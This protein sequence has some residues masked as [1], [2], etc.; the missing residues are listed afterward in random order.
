MAEVEK[1]DP[2]ELTPDVV[3]NDEVKAL[4]LEP[5]LEC[6]YEQLNVQNQNNENLT[7]KVQSERRHKVNSSKR[8]KHKKPDQVL[9]LQHRLP[10]WTS[11]YEMY[12]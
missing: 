7:V 3:K 4:S 8:K 12:G 9:N 6:P 5:E 1:T 10:K 11:F 2:F